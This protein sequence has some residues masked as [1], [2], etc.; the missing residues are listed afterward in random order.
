MARNNSTRARRSTQVRKDNISEKK[1]EDSSSEDLE[2][3]RALLT[4]YQSLEERQEKKQDDSRISKAPAKELEGMW[5]IFFENHKKA[6]RPHRIINLI[7][8]EPK[9]QKLTVITI[10][11]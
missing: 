8:K 9:F 5:D 2:A 10:E 1:R 3:S 7:M 4:K 6:K 11:N